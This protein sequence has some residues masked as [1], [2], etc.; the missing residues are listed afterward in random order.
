MDHQSEYSIEEIWKMLEDN[1]E[2]HL[3]LPVSEDI[4]EIKKLLS[5]KK[6]KQNEKLRQCGIEPAAATLEF[7]TITMGDKMLKLKCLLR[8]KEKFAI[9][10]VVIPSNELD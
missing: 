3:I 5:R 10:E 8:S 2:L 7:Q 9:S 4:N 1:G 6:G